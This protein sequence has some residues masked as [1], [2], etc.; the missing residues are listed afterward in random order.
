MRGLLMLVVTRAE[1]GDRLARQKC[2]VCGV[3]M[4][5][6]ALDTHKTACSRICADSANAALRRDWERTR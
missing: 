1:S 6:P 5:T 2:V 4:T 3:R